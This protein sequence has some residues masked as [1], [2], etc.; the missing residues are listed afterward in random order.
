[1]GTPMRDVRTTRFGPVETVSVPEA[2]IL[3]FPEGLPGF[4]GH[5]AF[6]LIEEAEH[7]PFAWLQSLDDAAVRFILVDPQLILADYAADLPEAD[8]EALRLARPEEARL[9]AILT[10]REDPATLTA[11]LKAPVVIN[12]PARRGRQV[13][14]ADERYSLRQPVV[15]ATDRAAGAEAD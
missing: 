12:M 1:M 15:P 6:A 5:R 7:Q 11:N 9:Y 4:E 8:V 10:I 2:A 13:I 3:D 14:L